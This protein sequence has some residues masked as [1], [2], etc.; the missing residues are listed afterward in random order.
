MSKLHVTL[1]FPTKESAFAVALALLQSNA[2]LPVES[3][4]VL[5]SLIALCEKEN[6][7]LTGTLKRKPGV[8]F[9]SDELKIIARDRLA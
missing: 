3:F 1:A 7:E 4:D 8:V 9:R 5:E 2:A 6:V